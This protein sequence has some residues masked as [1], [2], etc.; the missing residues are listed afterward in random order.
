MDPKLQ[1]ILAIGDKTQQDR[2]IEGVRKKDKLVLSGVVSILETLEEFRRGTP[3]EA[4]LLD[5]LLKAIDTH[6][7]WGTGAARGDVARIAQIGEQLQEFA[8]LEDL[9][10]SVEAF[11]L[12]I[13]K[14]LRG[15]VDSSVPVERFT[16]DVVTAIEGLQQE[17]AEL[18]R[19]LANHKAAHA[20]T[21]ADYTTHCK[22]SADLKQ[23]IASNLGVADN[24]TTQG[25]IDSVVE[26]AATIKDLESLREAQLQANKALVEEN[27]ALKELQDSR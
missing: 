1:E 7:G 2:E 9:N 5:D 13:A 16:M 23:A 26:A 22:K 11:K 27:K 24:V 3:E 18:E 4:Q 10:V 14:A 20:R 19:D 8:G 15:V 12:A 17:K 21:E 25:Y 6:L